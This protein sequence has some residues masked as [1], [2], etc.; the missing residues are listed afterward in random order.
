VAPWWWF[1]CKPKHVGAV[2]LILKCFNNSTFFNVVC[3][4]WKLKC[5]IL[6]MHGVTMKFNETSVIFVEVRNVDSGT[7]D[8]G[9]LLFNC[10]KRYEWKNCTGQETCLILLH[11]SSLQSILFE[12]WSDASRNTCRPSKLS[13]LRMNR[14][15]TAF[16]NI[17]KTTN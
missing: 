2:L 5:W 17:C 4:S 16:T 3:F 1:P 9:P 8:R 15:S 12:L 11:V 6:L 13:E 7:L 14:N 10:L